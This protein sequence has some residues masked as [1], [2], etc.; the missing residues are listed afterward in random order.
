[1]LEGDLTDFTLPD[2]LRLL[3]LTSKS[4]RL[5]LRAGHREG[6]VDL[7]EGRVRDAS[8]DATRLPLARRAL[9][10]GVIDGEPVL[11]AVQGRDGLPTDLELARTL[12]GAGAVEASLL[13][14]LLREQVTD[15]VFDLLRWS[16]G[17]FRFAGVGEV[18]GPSVL[19]LAIPVEEVLDE[20]GHRLEAWPTL[21]ERTGDLDAVVVMSAPARERVEVSLPPDGWTLLALVDGRRSVA[22]LV[23]LSG[24]GEY[25]TRRILAALCDEGVVTIGADAAE[26]PV[27]QLLAAHVALAALEAGTAPVASSPPTPP[28]PTTVTAPPAPPAG[29]GADTPRPL[30]AHARTGRLRTDPSVDADLVDRLIEGVEA[31]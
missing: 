20:A 22:D 10:T 16:E 19:D 21:A 30:R 23:V 24:L 27:G 7:V 28:R 18:R 4:G 11:A 5:R 8:A 9:G 15:A 25:R 26:G 17:T 29:R 12:V 2:L 3:A 13:A 1:V 14:D 6:R 31:L